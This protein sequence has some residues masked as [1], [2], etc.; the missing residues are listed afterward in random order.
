MGKFY[1]D[2]KDYPRWRD[3]GELVHRTV[4][5]PGEGEVVHHRDGNPH[6]FRRENLECMDRGDHARLEAR[7]RR[8]GGSSSRW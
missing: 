1:Y 2:K 5:R 3:S 6:N 7:R 8:S 4:A